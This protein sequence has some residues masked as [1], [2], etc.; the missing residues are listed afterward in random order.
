M[1]PVY[2][3]DFGGTWIRMGE[4]EISTGSLTG[5]AAAKVCDIPDGDIS[6]WVL[7]NLDRERTQDVGVA[8]AGVVDETSLTIHRRY[9]ILTLARNLSNAGLNVAL[10]NDVQAA[11]LAAT[12]YGE[13]KGL[14][15]VV[16][17]T[18][19]TGFNAA[20]IVNGRVVTEAEFGHQMHYSNLIHQFLGDCYI[21]VLPCDSCGGNNHL[22]TF[23]SANGAALMARAFLDFRGCRLS[24]NWMVTMSFL[25]H[26]RELEKE[27]GKVHEHWELGYPE[28]Y[29]KIVD[30]IKPEHVYEA[31]SIN[32]NELP[33][34]SIYDVQA[35]AIAASFGRIVAAYNPV[36]MIL[37]MG[38][39]TNVKG[40]F[41]S[42]KDEYEKRL[43]DFQARLLGTP[44]IVKTQLQWPGVQ[45]AALYSFHKM[46][47]IP[48]GENVLLISN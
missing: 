21:T 33:Q 20:K 23:A 34:K 13:A 47:N 45:G 11:A 22:E 29:S 38:G 2:G 9:M 6:R 25:D 19:S 1:K 30:L 32:R 14:E 40:L 17:A 16:L 3:I 43:G 44:K 10:T 48:L 39:L 46:H 24:E 7:S 12:T 42:A 5:L 18:Y 8:A 27:G 4:V 41:E 36:Q 35:E 28:L 37:M 26:N 31:V 15:H